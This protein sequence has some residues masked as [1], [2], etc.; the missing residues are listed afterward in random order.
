MRV[1]T[2]FHH[3]SLA[4]TFPLHHHPSLPSFAALPNPQT[5]IDGVRRSE[6]LKIDALH[7]GRDAIS[8]SL[9]IAAAEAERACMHDGDEC[10]RLTEA[11]ASRLKEEAAQRGGGG[12]GHGPKIEEQTGKLLRQ[13]AMLAQSL[14]ESETEAKLRANEMRE[15]AVALSTAEA[16]AE[17]AEELAKR[18]R[19]PPSHPVVEAVTVVD[20][21]RIDEL[22]QQLEWQKQ[23]TQEAN[24]EIKEKMSEME[25]L[26]TRR[27]SAEQE[28][29]AVASE[30]KEMKTEVKAEKLRFTRV[31]KENDMEREGRVAAEKRVEELEGELGVVRMNAQRLS[32]K[33]EDGVAERSADRE[34][35]DKAQ[36]LLEA[37]LEGALAWRVEALRLQAE[38]SRSEEAMGRALGRSAGD[39][40]SSDEAAGGGPGGGGQPRAVVRKASTLVT[41][42]ANIPSP[43]PFESR[44]PSGGSPSNRRA[45]VQPQ[46][47]QLIGASLS[48]HAHALI[49]RCERGEATIAKLTAELH[50]SMGQ[51]EV[52]MREIGRL[53]QVG[54]VERA[55]LV[56]QAL[57]SLHQLRSH[58]TFAL[59]GLR[60]N[61]QSENVDATGRWRKY[62]GL[63][64]PAGDVMVVR[65]VP[66]NTAGSSSKGAKAASGAATSAR[67]IA[68]DEA[69]DDESTHGQVAELY[70][71]KDVDLSGEAGRSGKRLT[72]LVHPA[73]SSAA[74]TLPGDETSETRGDCGADGKALPILTGTAAPGIAAGGAIQVAPS[75]PPTPPFHSD[76]RS[77]DFKIPA[78]VMP[79]SHRWGA[80]S[81]PTRRPSSSLT[82]RLPVSAGGGSGGGNVALRNSVPLC[83]GGGGGDSSGEQLL[84]PRRPDSARMIAGLTR[85]VVTSRQGSASSRATT[86]SAGGGGF[87]SRPRSAA[88]QSPA[89]PLPPPPTPHPLLQQ[90]LHE[91]DKTQLRPMTA[92]W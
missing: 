2:A 6:S 26:R 28:M 82:V 46:E 38:V 65:F 39:P 75:V 37:D 91:R 79:E 8:T 18:P 9:V 32:V 20:N 85:R 51:S 10:R 78:G 31:S 11:L 59:S 36:R 71:L 7:A 50:T 25:V 45:T 67:M 61:Q 72:A 22:T 73:L 86:V 70:P 56:R 21:T 66:G 35:A 49:A 44:P 80:A 3:L 68:E 12:D 62:A 63:V 81:R 43:I 87:T 74:F 88:V 58:L 5:V 30:L 60:I 89:V 53:Q 48:T 34:R 24:V 29:V 54:K 57:A 33:V 19:T 23:L 15:S 27:K 4:P 83:S 64:S 1:P 92:R 77:D 40:S 69:V 47:V 17:A 76:A 84:S 14:A 52:A 13:M 42:L 41:R 55:I 90:A 16:R